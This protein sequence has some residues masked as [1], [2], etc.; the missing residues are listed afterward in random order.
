M[1]EGITCKLNVTDIQLTTKNC[2]KISE[3]GCWYPHPG[4]AVRPVIPALL[5]L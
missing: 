3:V 1:L 5:A 4:T 2:P